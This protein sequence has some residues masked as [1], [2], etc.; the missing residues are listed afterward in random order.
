MTI[1]AQKQQVLADIASRLDATID[2]FGQPIDQGIR[3]TVLYLQALGITTS[4]SCEGHRD[5]GRPWPWIRIEATGEPMFR[6][7]NE[8]EIYNQTSR[9]FG[10]SVTDL[11]KGLGADLARLTLWQRLM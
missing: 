2:A 6:F 3:S 7:Q 4:Q 10:V 5:H 8:L 9:E 1:L 11:Q